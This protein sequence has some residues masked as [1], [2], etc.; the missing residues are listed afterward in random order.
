[1]TVPD[2]TAQGSGYYRTY[3]DGQEVSQHTTERKAIEAVY[4]LREQHPAAE[5]TYDHDYLVVVGGKQEDGDTTEVP[6][7]PATLTLTE[8]SR[9]DNSITYL[10]EWDAVDTVASYEYN[11]NSGTWSSTTDTSTNVTLSRDDTERTDTICVRAVNDAGASDPVCEDALVPAV[12]ADDGDTLTTDPVLPQAFVTESYP[13]INR[14]VKVSTDA[15]LSDA[16]AD[17]QPGDEIV[18][19]NSRTWGQVQLP[20]FSGGRVTLR[21]EGEIPPQDQRI[22]PNDNVTVIEYGGSGGILRADKTAGWH[23]YGLRAKP[24][25]ELHEGV[26]VQGGE[27][28]TLDRIHVLAPGTGSGDAIRR[29]V[30]F[31]AKDARLINSRIEGI[32]RDGYQSQGVGTWSGAGPYLIENN[33]IESLNQ[34]VLCGGA[35]AGSLEKNPSDGIIRHNHLYKR[36]SWR[37]KIGTIFVLE[38]KAGERWLAEENVVENDFFGFTIAIKAPSTTQGIEGQKTGDLTL[39]RNRYMGEFV[40]TGGYMIARG[41]SSEHTVDTDSVLLEDEWWD[42]REGRAI[43]FLTSPDN[44]TIRRVT[45]PA[46]HSSTEYIHEAPDGTSPRI[47]IKDYKSRDGLYSIWLSDADFPDGYASAYPQ[48]EIYD[49]YEY[50]A[51]PTQ[52]RCWRASEIP[53]TI[54][55][56]YQ[57]ELHCV[58]TEADV[59]SDVGANEDVVSTAIEGVRDSVR[60]E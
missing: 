1:M 20:G 12:V 15:E 26:S 10:A 19:S 40:G 54:D 52:S 53:D 23:V 49:Y 28:I 21:G 43:R 34:N 59:P 11:V 48:H 4:K 8:S 14:T 2:L 31:N 25:G 55:A 51:D 56:E 38:W 5:V 42:E 9:T 58:E 16:F 24:V 27:N 29:G 60:P 22:S 13:E 39:R 47:S 41:A 7:S 35:S 17:L 50:W 32:I 37:D 33:F 3:V 57:D 46:T 30:T 36:P 18:L 45:C 6:A 44:I